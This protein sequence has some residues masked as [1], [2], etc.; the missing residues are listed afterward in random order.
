MGDWMDSELDDFFGHWHNYGDEDYE[1]PDEGPFH[2]QE[3]Y[4]KFCGSTKVFWTRLPSRKF[5]LMD[6]ST[7]QPHACTER[8]E[9]EDRDTLLAIYEQSR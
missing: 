9:Q 8:I 3:V 5:C 7:N 6:T 2:P 1:E 4:C